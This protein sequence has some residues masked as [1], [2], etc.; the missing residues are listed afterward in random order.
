MDPTLYLN[1]NLFLITN[2]CYEKQVYIQVKG[3]IRSCL[4]QLKLVEI[5]QRFVLTGNIF[6]GKYFW[7][8][9]FFPENIL[10]GNILAENILAGKS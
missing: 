4:T 3:W 7:Q 9:I 1:I 5:D 10:A 6:G 8:E 2:Y